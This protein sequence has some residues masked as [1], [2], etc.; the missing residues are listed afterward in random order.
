TLSLLLLKALAVAIL[1]GLD[2]ILGVLI[3]GM[4]LG[5]LESVIPAYL[6]PYVG[7]GSRDVVASMVILLTVIFRPHGLFGREDIER[8]SAM[9]YRPSG[10]KHVSYA[11]DRQLWP[12]PFDPYLVVAAVNL[13]ITAPFYLSP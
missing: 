13:R 12:V 4:I 2:S 6:D 7:G 5:V 3:A 1:G 11:A 8:V 10:I 9:F